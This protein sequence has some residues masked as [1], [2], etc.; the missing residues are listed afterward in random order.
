[1][2]LDSVDDD[3]EANSMPAMDRATFATAGVVVFVVVDSGVALKVDN[4]SIRINLF[5]IRLELREVVEDFF[6][7]D[8]D[9]TSREGRLRAQLRSSKSWGRSGVSSSSLSSRLW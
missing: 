4:E 9:V 3:E 2:Q 6:L 1:M 5:H 8:M 7:R